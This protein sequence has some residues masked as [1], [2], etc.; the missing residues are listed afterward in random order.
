MYI[1]HFAEIQEVHCVSEKQEEL[2]G[3]MRP[4]FYYD[5]ELTLTLSYNYAQ[6]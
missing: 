3:R 2:H 1:R 5:D 4:H 6:C